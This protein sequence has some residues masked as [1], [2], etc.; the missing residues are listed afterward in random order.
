MFSN[1]IDALIG[2]VGTVY[3]VT[4]LGLAVCESTWDQG[5][6]K[7]LLLLLTGPIA[8]FL[9]EPLSSWYVNWAFPPD[10]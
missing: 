8:F 6:G 5:F 9:P 2:V 7:G 1:L 3:I 10:P 4:L